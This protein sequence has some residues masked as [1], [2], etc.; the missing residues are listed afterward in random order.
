MTSS[1]HSSAPGRRRDR[2]R[3]CLGVMVA[4]VMLPGCSSE[5]DGH[6]LGEV[7]CGEAE[8]VVTDH[9]VQCWNID[10]EYP[11]AKSAFEAVLSSA[12]VDSELRRLGVIE[13]TSLECP[14]HPDAEF[15]M[16]CVLGVDDETGTEIGFLGVYTDYDEGNVEALS[17]GDSVGG[18]VLTYV[19]Y[20]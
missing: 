17:D 5:G 14:N 13:P 8:V 20:E 10:G 11:G 12:D 16:L 4:L 1:A 3:A 9:T 18:F 7:P 2:V 6:L 15:E 19:E